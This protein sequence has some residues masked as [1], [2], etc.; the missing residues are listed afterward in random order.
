M[1]LVLPDGLH[2]DYLKQ[3]MGPDNDDTIILLYRDFVLLLVDGLVP[4]Y[5]RPWLAGGQLLGMGKVDAAGILIPLD[6]N[7][8]PI[9]MRLIWRKI[10]FK[11]TLA[12][13]KPRIQKRVAPSQRAGTHYPSLDICPPNRYQ[14]YFLTKGYLKCLQ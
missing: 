11:C 3:I 9:V 2:T 8:P 5:L 13:D 4:L 12:M 10:A 1:G 6:Y 14:L 7:A